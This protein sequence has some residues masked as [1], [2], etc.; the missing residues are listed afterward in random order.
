MQRGKIRKRSQ[1]F[2]VNIR[3]CVITP[4]C[5]LVWFKM[6]SSSQRLI[7]LITYSRADTSKI[8]NKERFACAVLQAW[9]NFGIRVIHW[10]A[11]IEA[12]SNNE[13]YEEI[14]QF[15]FHMAVKLAKKSRWLQ[16]RNY[17]DEN[18]GIQVNFSDNHSTYYTAY[19]YVTKEDNEALHSPG[20]PDLSDLV[21]RTEAAISS[22][23]RKAKNKSSGPVK[24][25][26]QRSKRLSVYDVCQIVQSKG[27]TSRLELVCL[28]VQQNREGKTAL[29]QFIANRGNK[30]VDEAIELAKEFSQAES[31]YERATKTRIELLQQQTAIPCAVGCEGRW[32]E[33]A[34]QLLQ[35][36]GI[37]KE[38]FCS[39]VYT[40]LC[41]GRG[42]YRN[43][44]IYGDTNCGKSFILSPLKVIYKTFC[45]PATGSFAWLGA[46]DAELIF[47]NDFRWHPKI[48]AWADF[49]QALEGDT[50]HLPA[51]KNVCSRDLELNKDTPFFATSD[52]PLVLIKGGSMDNTNTQMMNVRWKF[53]HFWSQIPAEEQHELVPCG[54]CFAKFIL[55]HARN[56]STASSE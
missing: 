49:L 24:K 11:C 3:R 14:N 43:I 48:I 27:I 23:K 45:N 44:Y 4:D 5:L 55:D 1:S 29:A 54:H 32:F 26:S 12:H 7:Y 36:H 6:E 19:Q 15:H 30:A 17:L 40:A 41:K 39:A 52:A 42:K 16:V 56:Q 20:H 33:A 50:V 51:P 21:T 25:S 28:A 8:S 2:A 46:E 47:L 9:Q 35:R 13:S 22:R 53:F 31:R 38:D 10:V 37:I 34:D 18:Y